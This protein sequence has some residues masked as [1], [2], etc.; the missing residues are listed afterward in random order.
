MNTDYTLIEKVLAN[1]LKPALQH[2]IHQDQKGFLPGRHIACNIR[3][4]LDIIEVCDENDLPFAILSMDFEKCFDHV[5]IPALI[6]ALEYFEVG[7]SYI[8]W[9]RTIY[10]GPEAA[11]SNN[12]FVSDWFKVTRSV[13]QGGPNSAYLF[14][15]IAEVLAIKLRTCEKISGIVLNDIRRLLGQFA[16]DMDLY[17]NGNDNSVNKAIRIIDLFQKNSGFKVNYDKTA[18]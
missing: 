18:I 6:K 1:R 7:S 12:G 16:D 17:L 3:R 4:I 5:E 14:L 2:L 15:I 13:K 8:K 11:I 10:E 9:I